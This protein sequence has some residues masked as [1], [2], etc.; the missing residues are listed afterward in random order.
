MKKLLTI[1]FCFILAVNIFPA[2]AMKNNDSHGK[3]E[4]YSSGGWL[5][6][7]DGVKIL[8]ISGSNY[9]MGYQHGSLLKEEVKQDIRGFLNYSWHNISYLL[10]IWNVMKDYVPQEYIEEMQGLADGA[11]ISFEELAAANMV[12]IVGDMGGCF[13]ISA[14]GNATK[15]GTLYHARSFDISFN[16]QDPVTGTFA[17]EN[18][19]LIVRNPDN[20]YAS[21]IPTVAGSMHGGGGINEQGIAVGQQICPSKKDQTLHGMP[22]Q[23]RVQQVL[24]HASTAMDAIEFLTSNREAGWNFIV[25]DSKIPAGYVVET[26]AN[27]TYIGTYNDPTEGKKP[28]WNIDDVVRRTNFFIN[29]SIAETQ[30]ARFNPSGLMSF[31]RLVKRTDV[32]YAVWRSYKVCSEGIEKN[33]GSL[34]LNSTMTMLRNCY[35]GKTDF[36][37]RLI[38]YLAK[39]T[40]FNRAFNMWVANPEN[41]DMV[42][43]FATKDNIAFSNPVHYFK[44]YNLLNATPP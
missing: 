13:G 27:L 16:I 25:S 38:V 24:D 30:R 40:S 12:I 39:G 9:E 42:V 3:S 7:R 33:W 5:E 36:L 43:C 35:S 41:G 1:I 21:L 6:V 17:R 44:F 32:F 34:D 37:L 4:S 19:V 20:G 22:A 26:T 11:G 31:I 23:F 29:Q 8:H 2:N 28:F 18:S 14:W 10:S 15:D